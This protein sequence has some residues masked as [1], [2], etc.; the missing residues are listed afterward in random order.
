[1]PFLMKRYTATDPKAATTT[2]MMAIVVTSGVS[3]PDGAFIENAKS[4]NVALPAL[5][6]TCSRSVWFPGGSPPAYMMPDG[7]TVAFD[8]TSTPS[9]RSVTEPGR[10]PTSPEKE[11]LNVNG[12][13]GSWEPFENPVV[14]TA[15]G[16]T[17]L[18]DQ[19][20]QAA[21]PALS[22]AEIAT[23]LMPS[24]WAVAVY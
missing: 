20:H 19:L 24:G 2:T 9:I 17:T 21:L 12:P 8:V 5:L 13:L 6:V 22:L 16:V 1:L 14:M 7:V 4:W 11:A 23:V 15:A 18:N 10:G 3:L